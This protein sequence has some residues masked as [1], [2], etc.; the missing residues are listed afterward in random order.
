MRPRTPPEREPKHKHKTPSK[1]GRQP[2]HDR[3]TKRKRLPEREYPHYVHVHEVSY[4]TSASDACQQ[5]DA[6]M[7]YTAT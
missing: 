4:D 6:P 2:K 5:P 3:E 7:K 1:R